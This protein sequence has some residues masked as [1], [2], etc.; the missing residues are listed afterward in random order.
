[1]GNLTYVTSTKQ[2][3]R[4]VFS[5][6]AEPLVFSFSSSAYFRDCS[7]K[8]SDLCTLQPM[9]SAAGIAAL[10]QIPGWMETKFCINTRC[11]P[12]YE[13]ERY[14]WALSL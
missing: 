13:P 2:K 6:Q 1:M 5:S 10:T 3:I 12:V 8:S 7:N 9:A 4:V 14:S 11:T